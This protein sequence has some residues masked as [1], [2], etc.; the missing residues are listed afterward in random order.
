MDAFEAIKARRSVR[1]YKDKIIPGELLEKI[2]DA[3]RFAATARNIQPWRFIV[4]TGKATLKKLAELA[5]NGKFI[6]SSAACIVV[7]CEDTKYCLE[8][9]CAATQNIL[10][11][12]C[13]EKIGS[14]WV[15]GDK[16]PYAQ[17]VNKLLGAPDKLKLISLIALGYPETEDAFKAADKISLKELIHWEKF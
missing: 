2:V 6:G 11:A 9:G 12:A 15:A 5:D 10:V 1:S 14:C 7:F 3:A 16:K 13:A 17:A 8:D 4:V